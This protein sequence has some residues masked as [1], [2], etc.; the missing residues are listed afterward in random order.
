MTKKSFSKSWRGP[1]SKK[2]KCLRLINTSRWYSFGVVFGRKKTTPNMPWMEEV[3]TLLG[4]KVTVINEFDTY[5]ENLK[6]EINKPHGS[7]EYKNFR[8]KS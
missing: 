6:K 4:E 7:M 1:R 8:R 5:S 2:K 3:K